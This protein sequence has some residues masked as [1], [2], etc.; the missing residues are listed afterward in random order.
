[1]NILGLNLGFKDVDLGSGPSHVGTI[2]VDGTWMRFALASAPT[3][4]LTR[5]VGQNA[6]VTGITTLECSWRATVVCLILG[7]DW[8]S[9]GGGALGKRLTDTVPTSQVS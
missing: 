8:S 6:T 3:Q 4:P 5:Q 7:G 9:A 1:M 2:R